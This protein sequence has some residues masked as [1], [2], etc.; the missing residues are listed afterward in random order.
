MIINKAYQNGGGVFLIPFILCLI[1]I[2]MPMLYL[3]QAVGQFIS[4][5][6]IRSW[7]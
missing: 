5:G 4:R 1:L 6:L 7:V 3:E 2:G